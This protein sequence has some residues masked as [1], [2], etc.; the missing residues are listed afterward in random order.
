MAKVQIPLSIKETQEGLLREKFSCVDLVDSYLERI[1]KYNQKLN[2]FLTVT[3][4]GAYSQ[5]KKADKLINDYGEKA[6]LDYP[7]LGV[8][9]A[10]KDLFL[11]KGVRTTAGSQV[12]R[13]Y[14]PPYSAT[15]VKRLEEA[16]CLLLGKTNCDAW[17]H[18]A[19]GEN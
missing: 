4:E 17:A 9:V 15:V 16:G 10:H 6:F 2:C 13:S 8:T 1:D 19:S 18:G 5:A 12:L 11:T 3:K 7:L 14:I